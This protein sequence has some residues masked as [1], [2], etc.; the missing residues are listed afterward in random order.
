[1]KK[2]LALVVAVFAVFA[3]FAVCAYAKD[4]SQIT[5]AQALDASSNARTSALAQNDDYG[6]QTGSNPAQVLYEL[7]LSRGGKLLKTVSILTGNGKQGTA[8]SEEILPYLNSCDSTGCSAGEVHS[9]LMLSLTPS[10]DAD[11]S[12]FTSYKIDFSALQP[13]DVFSTAGAFYLSRGHKMSITHNGLVLT[14]KA[15]IV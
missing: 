4:L 14:I 9:G 3:V 7:T 5:P 11:G 1:M 8:S 6:A 2:T 12:I 15:K 13:A 10:V